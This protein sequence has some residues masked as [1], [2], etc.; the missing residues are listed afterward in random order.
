MTVLLDRIIVLAFQAIFLITPILVVH[1]NSEVFEFNKIVF[2][3]TLT[4][5]IVAAWLIKMLTLGKTIFRKTSLDGPLLVFLA[6]QI[7]AT[8]LS[9]DPR[10]SIFGYYSRFNG[11]LLS[12]FAY[13]LLY[14]S[15]VSNIK[16]GWLRSILLPGLVAATFTAIV[17]TLEHFG[18]FPT[19]LPLNIQGLSANQGTFNASQYLQGLLT[20]NC[21]NESVSERVFA[22]FGQPNWLA[23]FLVVSIPLVWGLLLHKKKFMAHA[24]VLFYALV[25]FYTKSR[26][27]LVALVAGTGIFWPGL[28]VILKQK[29][30]LITLAGLLTL[31]LVL[32]LITSRSW[33]FGIIEDPYKNPSEFSQIPESPNSANEKDNSSSLIT[34]TIKMRTIVWR[35]ALSIWQSRPLFGTGPETFAYA[36]PAH[37]PPEANLTLE[38]NHLY[39]KAHNEYLNYLANS[40]I[41]GLTGYLLLIGYTL[42]S[43]TTMVKSLPKESLNLSLALF[44]GYITILIT[45]FFGFSVV[46]TS[47]LFFLLPA[48]N[49]SLVAPQGMVTKTKATKNN[50]KKAS[51]TNLPL[52][53]GVVLAAIYILVLITN[54]WWA[55]HLYFLAGKKRDNGK[56][57][58]ARDNLT[59]ALAI[60]PQ[61]AVFWNRQAQNSADLA[62]AHFENADFTSAQDW[63]ESSFEETNQATKLSPRDIILKKQK[64]ILL[65]RLIEVDQKYFDEATHEYMAAITLAP[66]DAKLFYNFSLLALKAGDYTSAISLME[67]A[68]VI[69]E[70]FLEARSALALMYQDV[71]ELQKAQ[72]VM[73]GNMSN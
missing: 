23:A 12:V 50:F 28:F 2:V 55:D 72:E 15:F 14:W 62:I 38:W 59:K 54:Y 51:A 37:K 63:S 21:W 25:I 53:I 73:M 34:S 35:G 43:F 44:T 29:T 18:Y 46:V 67:R 19:C 9:I 39:D 7:V 32:G 13:S 42:R 68:L 3:Y 36:Y 45:N 33:I 60:S 6:T 24:L 64:A 27:G 65:T 41:F 69:K 58:D 31:F 61:E 66:T 70:N 56:L 40:G 49:F 5:I 4:T 17:G 47:L 16:A 1:Q 52:T 26:S 48:C 22:T 20:K 8:V 71:G 57:F 30:A 11:G 10:T